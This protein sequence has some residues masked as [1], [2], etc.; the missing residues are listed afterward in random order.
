VFRAREVL[1]AQQESCEKERK[2]KAN[3]KLLKVE[4][5]TG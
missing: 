2:N 1:T 4:D 5:V 3:F